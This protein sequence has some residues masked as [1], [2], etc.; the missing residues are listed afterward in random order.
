MFFSL[1]LR[2]FLVKRCSVYTAREDVV[3]KQPTLSLLSQESCP[4]VTQREGQLTTIRNLCP[5]PLYSLERG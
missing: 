2:A 4:L 5:H 1:A 3:R